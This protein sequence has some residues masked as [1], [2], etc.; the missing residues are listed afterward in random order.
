VP[1][2][3]GAGEADHGEIVSE[4]GRDRAALGRRG[5]DMADR[6]DRRDVQV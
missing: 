1:A 2:N 3:D 4:P 5:C 6:A